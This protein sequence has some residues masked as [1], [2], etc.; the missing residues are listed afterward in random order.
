M[1]KGGGASEKREMTSLRVERQEKCGAFPRLIGIGGDR[2]ERAHQKR[3]KTKA[4]KKGTPMDG[5]KKGEKRRKRNKSDRSSLNDEI[6]GV[7]ILSFSSL[8]NL[9]KVK[10]DMLFFLGRQST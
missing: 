10:R 5:R 8:R 2:R 7:S 4:R 1:E 9:V 3:K 6:P